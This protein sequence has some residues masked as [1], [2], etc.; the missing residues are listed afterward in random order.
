MRPSKDKYYLNI[1]KAVAARSTCLR[2]QYGAVVVKNDRIVAT[3]YNGS[4]RGAE[5]CCDR[6][7][8]RREDMGVAHGERYELCSSVHAEQ[9]A[10]LQCDA[11]NAEGATLYLYGMENEKTINAE[12]CMMCS[13]VIKNAGIYCVIASRDATEWPFADMGCTTTHNLT[14]GNNKREQSYNAYKKNWPRIL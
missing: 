7:T 5:N 12:P 2:R 11:A 10:L 3:G 8:C 13:R 9:N 4:P 14:G 6:G 1:A